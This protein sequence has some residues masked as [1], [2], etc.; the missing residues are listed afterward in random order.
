M[1]PF[2]P[3]TI[4]RQFIL[5]FIYVHLILALSNRL[6]SSCSR[7]LYFSMMANCLVW[8]FAVLALFVATARAAVIMDAAASEEAASWKERALGHVE[9]NKEQLSALQELSA[10]L[11][12]K[13]FGS[14]TGMRAAGKALGANWITYFEK[15]IEQIETDV[16]EYVPHFTAFYGAIPAPAFKTLILDVLGKMIEQFK[17]QCGK[18]E[19]E[20]FPLHPGLSAQKDRK[21][22]EAEEKMTLAKFGE[23]ISAF[24]KDADA[25]LVDFF[26]KFFGI[27]CPMV[28]D[29]LEALKTRVEGMTPEEL[30]P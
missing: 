20:H 30:K 14:Y 22:R 8:K 25:G 15:R 5:F 1:G 28:T 17:D 18:V 27:G 12:K 2:P 11:T 29:G 21:R 13:M 26:T 16:K 9:A 10:E 7:H 6:I 24:F 19:L 4:G 23:A 3:P